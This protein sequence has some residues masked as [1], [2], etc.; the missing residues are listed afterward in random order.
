MAESL[1]EELGERIGYALA[2]VV[3]GPAVALER[4]GRREMRAAL[5]EWSASLAPTDLVAKERGVLR[6]NVRL[7]TTRDPI[8]ADVT[9]DPF[10]RRATLRATT[11][12]LPGYVRCTVA[13]APSRLDGVE[14]NLPALASAGEVRLDSETLDPE[15]GTALVS[16]L[17][18]TA[19][20][21]DAFEIELRSERT[22]IRF[23]APA[24]RDGWRAVEDMTRALSAWLA[25]K[26]PAS[27]RT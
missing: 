23:L 15:T 4:R 12:M 10:A 11:Q 18:A 9:L 14:P 19:S 17:A 25:E 21:I 5:R 6:R 22:T 26:W 7:P 13:R 3:L 20:R 27:Y 2:A 8:V 16:A 1:W 24:H